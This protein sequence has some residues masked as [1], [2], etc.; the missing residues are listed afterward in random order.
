MSNE[1]VRNQRGVKL[2][3]GEAVPVDASDAPV[4]VV[5]EEVVPINEP[6]LVEDPEP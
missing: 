1:T 6:L 2:T 4:E 3:Y 5:T